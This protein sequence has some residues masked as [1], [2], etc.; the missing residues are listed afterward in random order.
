MHHNIFVNLIFAAFLALLAASCVPKIDIDT[1]AGRSVSVAPSG[2]SNMTLQLICN[3][4]VRQ[5]VKV[6]FH[7]RDHRGIHTR[8]SFDTRD[9]LEM[10]W[11]A[12]AGQIQVAFRAIKLRNDVLPN[13]YSGDDGVTFDVKAILRT[14]T[15]GA[16]VNW[17]GLHGIPLSNASQLWS[18]T[19]TALNNGRLGESPGTGTAKYLNFMIH[20]NEYGLYGIS[21]DWKTGNLFENDD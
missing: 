7:Y 17:G 3:S 14:P 15:D 10:S 20:E 6:V 9:T 1:P 21:I 13:V 12:E 19:I 16:S 5:Y 8:G 4:S 18:R 2:D 11:P